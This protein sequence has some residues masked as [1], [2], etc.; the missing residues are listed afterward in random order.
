M[1]NASRRTAEGKTRREILRC[2]KRYIA[3]EVYQLLVNPHPT[4]APEQ[5]RT[6][7][8]QAGITLTQ[9]AEAL[10]TYPTRI[11]QLETGHTHN[12]QL[13]TQYEQWLKETQKRGCKS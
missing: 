2:L 3:R 8:E 10:S 11:S 12:H 5:L 6:R 9:A 4:P 7:R 1:S 13:A